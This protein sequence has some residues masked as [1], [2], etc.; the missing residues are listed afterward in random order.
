MKNYNEPHFPCQN[1]EEGC[2]RTDS[3][4]SKRNF[5]ETHK[6]IEKEGRRKEKALINEQVSQSRKREENG[7]WSWMDA[8][9]CRV[10]TEVDEEQGGRAQQNSRALCSYT[11]HWETHSNTF[12]FTHS[13]IVVHTSACFCPLPH[14]LALASPRAAPSPAQSWVSMPIDPLCFSSTDL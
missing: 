12:T 11:R 3:L 1:S 4:N 7:L 13:H 5:S 8:R 9:G 2:V 10:G 6:Q 14:R